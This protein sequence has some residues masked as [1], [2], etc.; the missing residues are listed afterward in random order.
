MVIIQARQF[1]SEIQMYLCALYFNL[2]NLANLQEP[3]HNLA[4]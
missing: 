1:V 2:L 3:S 4:F